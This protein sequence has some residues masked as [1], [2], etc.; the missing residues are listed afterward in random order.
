[1]L[2]ISKGID[3]FND[4]NF[5]EAHDY[6]EDIWLDADHD[7]RKFFQGMVQVSVGCYHLICGNKKGAES[8][9]TK[10]KNK[11]NEYLPNYYKVNI[12]K[13]ISDIEILLK[14][15][16]LEK[17]NLFFLPKIELIK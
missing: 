14:N 10:G 6:F 8:Q 15:V 16:Y 12:E 1:M 4:H 17:E 13:L 2:N 3:L 9:L 7:D 11:L 5:F